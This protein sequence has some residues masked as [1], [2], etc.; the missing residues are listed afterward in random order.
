[1]GS[2]AF[3]TVAPWNEWLVALMYD[4]KQG[5]PDLSDETL[6]RRI[7][8][9]IGD[10]TV[11]IEIQNVGKW[12]MNG[13]IA[14]SYSTDRIFCLGDAVHRHSPANGLGLNISMLDAY[15]LAWKLKLVLSGIADPILLRSYNAERQPVGRNVIRRSMQT[16]REAANIPAALGYRP[17]QNR[18]ERELQVREFTAPTDSGAAAHA[19]V[20][21][22]T[23]RLQS[24]IDVA[25][26]GAFH[27]LTGPG[28]D[29]WRAACD[30]ITERTG[31]DIKVTSIGPGC[32]F[33][34]PY[35][36]WRRIRGVGDSGAVLVRP[37]GH[38]AWRTPGV[39]EKQ[40]QALHD[41]VTLLLGRDSVA[42][43]EDS[44]DLS[45]TAQ[46]SH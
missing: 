40:S 19:Q 11:D 9:I 42:S 15:N 3:V 10:D 24:T 20:T 1:M 41:A 25:A 22:P 44:H 38:V 26:G 8:Q 14:S 39:D 5:E 36:E 46:L 2:G 33:G 37:D 23:G 27:L 4:P 28:G 45:R 43:P 32:S 31:L 35:G 16:V 30:E 13:Q 29:A 21:D 34:D 6:R 18:E 7:H 12:L 17:G